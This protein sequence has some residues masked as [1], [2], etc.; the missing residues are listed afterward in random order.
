MNLYVLRHAIAE[1]RG[2]AFSRD[3]DRPLTAEG[4]RKMRRIAKV[5]RDLHLAFDLILS[6]PFV[7][8][9][10]TAEIVAK[11]FDAHGLLKYSDDLTPNGKAEALIGTLRNRRPSAENVLLVGHEPY[12]SELISVLVGGTKEFAVNLKKGGFARLTVESPRYGRCARLDW[13]L[14]PRVLLRESESD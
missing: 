6:S 7:R 3:S 14:A 11:E 9:K 1:P 2:A 12:L 10:Q 13:L 5:M 4:R 8:A